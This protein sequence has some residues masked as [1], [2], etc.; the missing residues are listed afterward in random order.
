MNTSLRN[1]GL[2]F[3]LACLLAVQV[4]AQ[5]DD[6]NTTKE[7]QAA[8]IP[9]PA[10]HIDGRLNEPIW[11][12]ATFVSDF[13]QKEPVEGG[14]PT[15][16]TEVA[17]LFDDD[18]VYFGA[19]MYCDHPDSLRMHLDRR[20]NQGP[21]EQIIV[22]LDCYRD[23]RT[24]YAFGV[25]TAGVRFDRFHPDDN[26]NNRDYS[27]NPVWEARTARDDKSWTAEMRIPFSQLR[28]VD[29]PQQ[30][31]GINFNRWTPSRNEDV[32]WVYVPRNETGYASRFGTLTGIEGIRP[33]RRLELL[34]YIAGDAGFT[35]DVPSGD[36]F[37]DGSDI[38]SRIG[39]DLKMGLGPNL[40]LDATFNPDF[41]Q[42]EADP[43]EV[44]LTAFETFFDERRPFFVEG[45]QLFEVEG[46]QFLYT[47]RIGG[48]PHGGLSDDHEYD[49]QPSNT[50][51]LGAGKVTGRLS[52]G[53][54]IG[55]ISA[56]T[57]RE[58]ADFADAGSNP[59]SGSERIEPRTLYNVARIQQEFGQDKSTAGLLLTSVNRNLGEGN[60]LADQ[61]HDQAY[62]G[63]ADWG[64]RFEGGKYDIYGHA[65]FTHVRGSSAAIAETQQS[66]THYFQ[67]PDQSHV[68]LDTTHTSL[69]GYSIGLRGGKRAGRHWLWGGGFGLESPEF[70]IND[71]GLLNTAD[72]IDAWCHLAYRENEPG[73][74]FRRYYVELDPS[75]GWNYGG[76][77]QYT[78]LGLYTE[79]TFTNYWNL[80]TWLAY[81]P[82]AQDDVKTRGG[83]LMKRP[84]SSQYE[85]GVSS[86][87]TS[88]T[89]YN[90]S[91][92]YQHDELDGF[93]LFVQTGFSTRIGNGWAVSVS[94]NYMYRDISRQYVAGKAG[95]PAETF[96]QRYI[97]ARAETSE[98]AV[99]I[100]TNYYFTPDLSLEVY[101]EPFAFSAHYHSFGELAAARSYDLRSYG[102]DGSTIADDE[103]SEEYTV[104]DNGGSFTISD[105]DRGFLSF[106]SNMVLRWEFQPGS[107]LYLVW[108]RNL[109]AE[110]DP[111]R[112]AR[113][114]SLLD[115]ITA[116]GNDVI[117]LKISYWIPIS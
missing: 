77:R 17:V 116:S 87:G 66:S 16:R 4:V 79:A 22:A 52:S 85:F 70:E 38:D 41:G 97:F 8:R 32:Y 101:A 105:P 59:A 78:E 50:T 35:A 27:Y 24:A 93:N 108:Q 46:N 15:H 18:A 91:G 40:T 84:A 96:G 72:D 57:D 58:Y 12:R 95:G 73:S 100:R 26:E 19:R 42:V 69:T 83:P 14:K 55:V 113:A 9:G 76:V 75:I 102:T 67:R 21:A 114:R 23:R 61:L 92:G 109:S 45:G 60:P 98:L 1:S 65:G 6:R 39:G 115:S 13:R 94:P 82:A 33:S 106:R 29:R 104:V 43:A 107:T 51:I 53:T 30:I 80:W 28:F 34:P 90:L 11:S 5:P 2:A 31:W 36:P 111:G 64:L 117:A 44:N 88:T 74:L 110:D 37:R 63:N 3:G 25:N 10:P 54:S 48:S 71:A 99:Q 7:M 89:S 20:D 62:T 112:R 68:T 86:N 81:Y 103:D 47:R 56:L 49:Y